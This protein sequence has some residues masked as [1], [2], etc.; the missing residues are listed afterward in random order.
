MILQSWDNKQGANIHPE[1]NVMK[2][3]AMI[4]MIGQLLQ[5]VEMILK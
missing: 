5:L 3:L 4:A 2:D 1:M